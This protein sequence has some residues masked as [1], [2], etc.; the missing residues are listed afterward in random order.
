MVLMWCSIS[1][2]CLC[3]ILGVLL[4]SPIETGGVQTMGFDGSPK[5]VDML[6]RRPAYVWDADMLDRLRCS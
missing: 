3:L 1:G 4:P 2:F 6:D 5:D